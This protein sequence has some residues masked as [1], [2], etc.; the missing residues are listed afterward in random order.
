[1]PEAR[2][3]EVGRRLFQIHKEKAVEVALEKIRRKMPSEWKSFTS[4][5]IDL[6]KHILGEVWVCIKRSEWEGISFAKLTKDDLHSIITIAK[7]VGNK[8]KLEKAAIDEV[9]QAIVYQE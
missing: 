9:C 1:M 5:D 6:L 2:D 7:Q 3:E 8:E 4:T